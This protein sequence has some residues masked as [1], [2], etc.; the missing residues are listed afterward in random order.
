MIRSFG[1]EQTRLVWEREHVRRLSPDVQRVAHKKLR[2]LNA[3]DTLNDLRS[4]PGNRLEKLT[5][6]RK[7]QHSIRIN[8]QFRVCFTWTAAGP[9]QVHIVD[10]H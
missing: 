3:A 6:S 9:S 7:G 10:Y 1:D 4:P 8:N 2:L 5:G